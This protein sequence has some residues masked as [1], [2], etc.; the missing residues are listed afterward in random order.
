MNKEEILLFIG[1]SI[2]ESGRFD[3]PED[4]GYGY[5][6]LIR[7]YLLVSY[8]NRCP[9]VINKGVAGNHST[10]L[11]SR[12]DKDVIE[13]NPD[14][15]SISIGINDVWRRLDHPEKELV[16]PERYEAI[17][18]L[19]LEEVK[20]KTEAQI[21]MMEPT[22]HGEEVHSPGNQ[23]LHEYVEVVRNLADEYQATLVPSHQ[24]FLD[25]LKQHPNHKLTSDGVHMNSSGNMLMAKTWLQ[26]F[27]KNKG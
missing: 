27:L 26:A 3:D 8:P 25:Y 7:D 14:Y 6:R 13:Y 9:K 10:D 23:M 1:D 11:V 18:R 17:I 2:T 19:L 15:V 5:V 24:A 21:I 20:I 4:I 12:W 22:I 16:F